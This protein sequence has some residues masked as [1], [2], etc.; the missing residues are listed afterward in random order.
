MDSNSG[1]DDSF[2]SEVRDSLVNVKDSTEQL[3]KIIAYVTRVIA[4]NTSRKAEHLNPDDSF[5]SLGVNEQTATE[6]RNFVAN[7]LSLFLSKGMF[8]E[9]NTIRSISEYMRDALNS[10]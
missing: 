9:A 8:T 6:I 5:A 1:A 10:R 2:K 3:D 7:E 4:L